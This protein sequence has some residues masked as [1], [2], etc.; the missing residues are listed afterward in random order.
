M[1]NNCTIWIIDDEKNINLLA[2]ISVVF[3]LNTLAFVQ[4]NDPPAVLEVISVSGTSTSGFG[5]SSSLPGFGYSAYG[6]SGGGNTSP[7]SPTPHTPVPEIDKEEVCEKGTRSAVATHSSCVAR[8]LQT[9][10]TTISTECNDENQKDESA[11]APFFY[12][13]RRF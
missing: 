4:Q 7:T 2:I 8:E 3:S 10:A 9:F 12:S 13:K 1:D 6:G 5:A 11:N